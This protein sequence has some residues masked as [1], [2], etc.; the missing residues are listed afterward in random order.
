LEGV[1]AGEAAETWV[2]GA[3]NETGIR[4]KP[5]SRARHKPGSR[6]VD[7]VVLPMSVNRS[8]PRSRL[9]RGNKVKRRSAAASCEQSH[10]QHC[11]HNHDR[12]QRWH[13]ES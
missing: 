10:D 11:E 8:S 6:E 13:L 1:T 3:R 2:V 4:H 5:G 12:S 9:V 7:C